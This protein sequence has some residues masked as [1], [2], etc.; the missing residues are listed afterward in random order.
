VSSRQ[1][2]DDKLK[3]ACRLLLTSDFP[4]DISFKIE[5]FYGSDTQNSLK[6]A[7]KI[8]LG[9]LHCVILQVL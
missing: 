3:G 6:K 7:C 1:H 5:S 4:I 8:F 9:F 2:Q